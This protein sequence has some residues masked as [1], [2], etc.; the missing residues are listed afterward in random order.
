[1]AK[2]PAWK[3]LVARIVRCEDNWSFSPALCR[4][5]DARLSQVLKKLNRNQLAELFER[6]AFEC[7]IELPS[8][9]LSNLVEHV[10]PATRAVVEKMTPDQTFTLSAYLWIARWMEVD[11]ITQVEWKDLRASFLKS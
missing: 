5:L 11:D 9:D 1:M 7:P 4:Y 8:P 10:R 6:K 3:A 2:K